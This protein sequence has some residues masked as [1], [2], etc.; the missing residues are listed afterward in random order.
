MSFRLFHIAPQ[1]RSQRLW[2]GRCLTHLRRL[3][4]AM[5][6]RFRVSGDGPRAVL[7]QPAQPYA[8]DGV[9]LPAPRRIPL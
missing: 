3:W 2:P 8:I 1:G 4:W 5:A 7:R 9:C 6:R